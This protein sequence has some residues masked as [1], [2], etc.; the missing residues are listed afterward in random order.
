VV[1]RLLE[2]GEGEPLQTLLANGSQ[3]SVWRGSPSPPSQALC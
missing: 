1:E 2:A 3:L